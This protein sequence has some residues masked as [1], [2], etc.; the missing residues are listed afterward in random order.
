MEDH[1]KRM[2]LGL[3]QMLIADAE[4]HPR[5]LEILYQ[6]GKEKGGIT[7][8][9]IQKAVFS[10]NKLISIDNLS[11]DERIEYLYHLSRIAWADGKVDTK[12]KEILHEA[13]IRFGFAEENVT[14]ITEFLLKQVQENKSIEEVL[15]T[16]KNS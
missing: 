14:E 13:S 12:E 4:V 1:D 9:E 5:E 7:E 16:I 15:L 2:F 6:I 11:N 8:D 3:Y 10:P